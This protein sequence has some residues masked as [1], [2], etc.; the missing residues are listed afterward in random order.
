MLNWIESYSSRLFSF[1]KIVKE[2]VKS[3]TKAPVE[4]NIWLWFTTD[5]NILAC[6]TR[7]MKKQQRNELSIIEH[8]ITKQIGTD[9]H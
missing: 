2:A 6:K 4:R 5:H 3:L 7:N 9:K 8:C 1:P